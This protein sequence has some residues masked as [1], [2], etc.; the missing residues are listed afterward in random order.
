VGGLQYPIRAGGGGLICSILT[1]DANQHDP[2]VTKGLEWVPVG[3]YGW[4]YVLW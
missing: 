2:T 3:L 1:N 4:S